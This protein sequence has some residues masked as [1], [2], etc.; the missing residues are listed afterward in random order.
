M[1]PKAT[2]SERAEVFVKPEKQETLICQH[3]VSEKTGN[4]KV[5]TLTSFVAF[6]LKFSKGAVPSPVGL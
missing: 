5:Q 3:L 1:L 2:I 6:I 4:S